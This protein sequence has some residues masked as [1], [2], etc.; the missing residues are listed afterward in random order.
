M[1]RL[2]ISTTT[3]GFMWCWGLSPGLHT[4]R[5]SQL[6]ELYAQPQS[7]VLSAGNF[8]A[9]PSLWLPGQQHSK[10]RALETPLAH[11]VFKFM[12]RVVSRGNTA[13]PLSS[14]AAG[15]SIPGCFAWTIWVS[16]NTPVFSMGPEERTLKKQPASLLL[17]CNVCVCVCIR[18]LL[19]LG[20]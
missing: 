15:Y 7:L 20:I 16:E 13:P 3:L 12:P 18:R 9:R 8:R 10:A 14:P 5:A 1:L 11:R 4:R 19:Q 2:Q 17:P 6:T